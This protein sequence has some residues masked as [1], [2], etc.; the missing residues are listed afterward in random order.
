[1]P[2]QHAN[3]FTLDFYGLQPRLVWANERTLTQEF[4]DMETTAAEDETVAWFIEEGEVTVTYPR[5]G[6]VN[7]RAGEWLLLRAANGSQHF[8]AGTRLMSLRFHLRLRGGK[9]L[10][11]RRRDV[12]V[13]TGDSTKLQQA[14]HKLVKEFDRVSAPGTV[15]VVRSRLSMVDNFRIEAAFMH[16]LGCYVETMQAEGEKPEAASRRDARVT[17][18]LIWIEDHPMRTKFSEAKLAK[19]CGLGINQLGRLFRADQGIS[20]FQYYEY[21]RVELAQQTLKDSTLPI[22]EVSFE[23]GFSSPPHFANWF[24]KRVGVSPRAWR[25]KIKPAQETSPLKVPSRRR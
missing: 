22:K 15:F 3:R 11:A 7:A 4:L 2:R 20:P 5:G 17:K 13:K 8:T 6:V 10:F 18:A 16:W 14:A 1:M 19:R 24:T 21:R 12:V 25:T 23:L 9:P